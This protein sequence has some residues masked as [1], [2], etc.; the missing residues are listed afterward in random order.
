MHAVIED[1]DGYI[2]FAGP[3]GLTR[4]DGVRLKT[5]GKPD[6]LSTQ[7]LRALALASDNSIWVGT[8]LGIDR[9]TQDGGVA[10]IVPPE[11]WIYGFVESMASVGDDV[12]IGTSHGV[13]RWNPE[14][15]IEAQEET[16]GHLIS[17]LQFDGRRLWAAGPGL[18]LRFYGD[19][20]W[21][22]PTADGWKAVGPITTLAVEPDGS[23]LVGG[24]RGLASCN[25]NGSLRWT[26]QNPSEG[27]AVSAVLMANEELW[28]GIH[29]ELRLY[30][31]RAEVW[32]VDQ[33]VMSDV[34]VNEIMQDSQDNIWVATDSS[35][36]RKISSLRHAVSSPTTPCRTQVYSIRRTTDGTFFIGGEQCSWQMD[37]LGGKV[38]RFESL[39]R[40]GVWDLIK[41]L[42]GASWAATDTGLYRQP[43]GGLFSRVDPQ[44]PILGVPVRVLL[45]RD[46][47]LWVGTVAGLAT[48]TDGVQA[49]VRDSERRSLGYVYTLVE[50]PVGRLWIGTIGRGLWRE[51]ENGTFS[52]FSND[53]VQPLG[54]VYSISFAND[55]RAAVI[56]DNRIVILASDMTVLQSI[57]GGPVAGWSATFTE[58]N[59]LW[60]GS[61]NGLLLYDL[62]SGTQRRRLTSPMGLAGYE[63]TTS[64]S[65]FQNPDGSLVCGLDSG[66]SVVDTG[67][68]NQISVYPEVRLS[69]VV[70]RNTTPRQ[71][72]GELSVDHGRWRVEFY[73]SSPWF[74]EETGLHF[75]HRLVGFDDAWSDSRPR[76]AF[77]VEYTGLPS[78]TY[79]LE[80]QAY[81][82]LVGRGPPSTLLSFQV[83]AP[84]WRRPWMIPAW[85][86]LVVF[87]TT[88]LWRWRTRRLRL[89]AQSLEARVNQRTAE[90]REANLELERVATHDHLTGLPNRRSL[91]DRSVR[92]LAIACRRKEPFGLVMFD[93]DRFKEV[94][95]RFGHREGDRALV[96]IATTASQALREGDEIF[97]YGGE[98]FIILLTHGPAGGF[99]AAAERV[100]EQLENHQF[101]LQSKETI[102]ITASFGVT[103]WDPSDDDVDSMIIRADEALYRAKKT[104]NAVAEL[105]LSSF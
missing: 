61:S 21:K 46:D 13:V 27:E 34:L 84:W 4:Y 77:P 94:N 58:N 99:C 54:N 42:N 60:V 87:L 17:A 6:G 76:D 81:S 63:F 101:V 20:G 18:G 16:S 64:R 55:G 39:D 9:V 38:R 32:A 29:G 98:E 10:S 37:L 69:E 96:H 22:A 24:Q 45:E 30:R 88:V 105:N 1:S 102:S 103:A 14:G 51:S 92:F 71:K 83:K 44:I 91:F 80:G 72:D 15:G 49:E 79:E 31:R 70:W 40:L 104:R 11:S 35:G 28:V 93:I 66:I 25:S 65:L 19:G 3:S 82:P 12:W 36:I 97:R 33:V 41:D 90:L 43:A 5:M 53:S 68:L 95:D 73:F 78:G 59:E 85:T 26:L 75:R 56:Q 74:I 62:S 100:R 52:Q 23:L 2:W 86:L 67:A 57:M 7:G 89:L 48:I 47:A 50:D 8:D